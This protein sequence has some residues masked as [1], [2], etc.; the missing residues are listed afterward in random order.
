MDIETA[1]NEHAAQPS[2]SLVSRYSFDKGIEAAT[3]RILAMAE[4]WCAKEIQFGSP[5]TTVTLPAPNGCVAS[6]NDLL[7][8]IKEE[9]I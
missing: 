3:A 4:A 2:I 9:L 7:D 1:W 5:E 6:A 8:Y